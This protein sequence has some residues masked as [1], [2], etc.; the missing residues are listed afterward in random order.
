[1]LLTELNEAELLTDSDP[2][3]SEPSSSVSSDSSS[4]SDSDFD[5]RLEADDDSPKIDLSL[6]V[7]DPE[8]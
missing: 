8:A 6:E 3:S 2:S 1:M 4:D 5:E 7:N